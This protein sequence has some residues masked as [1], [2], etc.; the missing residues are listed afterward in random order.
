MEELSSLI[1]LSGPDPSFPPLDSPFIDTSTNRKYWSST[2]YEGDSANV[3]TVVI[4][5]FEG[6]ISVGV[7]HNI[8]S[9]IFY[10]WPVRGGNGF[11]T[12]NW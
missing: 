7:T 3:W 9:N 2:N 5:E 4:N 6:I 11:A 1:D 8:K 12:G 10:V